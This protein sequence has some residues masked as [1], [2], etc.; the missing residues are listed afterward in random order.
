MAPPRVIA[1]Q[2]PKGVDVFDRLGFCETLPANV[3]CVDIPAANTYRQTD[4]N[5]CAASS[6][7][8]P[9]KQIPLRSK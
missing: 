9:R 6:T 1:E 5:M 3:V 4:M 7:S 2:G 8:L